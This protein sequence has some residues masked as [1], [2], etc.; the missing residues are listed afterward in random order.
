MEVHWQQHLIQT[1]PAPL[2]HMFDI[3]LDETLTVWPLDGSA[4]PARPDPSLR[5]RQQHKHSEQA[6]TVTRAE[7][8]GSTQRLKTGRKR[9]CNRNTPAASESRQGT[10]ILPDD[11]SIPWSR[12]TL[13]LTSTSPPSCRVVHE[14]PIVV[15]FAHC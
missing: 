9:L 8:C 5:D 1:L 2:Q 10:L 14:Q 3:R 13:K 6:G 4:R 7:Q 12:A 11:I 15:P